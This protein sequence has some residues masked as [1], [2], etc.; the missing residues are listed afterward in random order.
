MGLMYKAV[1]PNGLMLAIKKLH[2]FESFEKEFLLEIEILGR[3]RHKNLVPLICFCSEI[4]KKF[5]VY[6]YMSNGTLHQWLHSRPQVEGVKMRWSLRLRIALGIA[7]GLAWLHHNNVLLVAHLKINSSCILLDEKFEPK[8]S[9]FGN[10]NILMNTSGTLSTGD[11]FVVPHSSPVR[12]KEDVY[13]FGIL[14]LELV[15]G[16]ERPYAKTDSLRDKVCAEEINMIDECL[17]GQGFDEEIYETLRIADNCIQT[18][19]D[20]ATSMLE[21]YQSIRVIGMSRNEISVDSCI[22]LEGSEGD[23]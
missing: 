4:D 18:Y 12:Y 17:K 5:L 13:S 21:V 9:N 3:L 10:S 19:K 8:I 16:T 14:L 7:R 1:F 15:S 23:V 2:K 11:T 6:Q 20:G 22:D